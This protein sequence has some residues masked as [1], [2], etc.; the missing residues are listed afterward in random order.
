MCCLGY[1][2]YFQLEGKVSHVTDS[3]WRKNERKQALL[4]S[5]K[6]NMLE[7]FMSVS[8]SCYR[9]LWFW[10]LPF[11]W[12]SKLVL[13]QYLLIFSTLLRPF[14]SLFWVY[15]VLFFFSKYWQLWW[16]RVSL[17]QCD[18]VSPLICTTHAYTNVG[19]LLEPSKVLLLWLSK[20]CC[21]LFWKVKKNTL[22][23]IWNVLWIQIIL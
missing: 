21:S 20:E 23:C 5:A 22:K 3:V 12:T 9:S 15:A 17:R 11:K 8:F 19:K 16:V 2:L 1:T 13:N 14:A 7:W 4:N 10:V 18:P 6:S